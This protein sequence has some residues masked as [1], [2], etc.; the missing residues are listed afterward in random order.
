MDRDKTLMADDQRRIEQYDAAKAAA[1]NEVREEVA[2]QS[3]RL[4]QNDHAQTEEIGRD[5]RREAVNEVRATD[6]EVKRA[7]TV[8][9]ISQVIDYLFYI[10]YGLITL[11]IIFDLFGARRTND[12]RNLID[13]LSSPFLSPFR[14]LF[15]D[16]TAGQ[17]QIRF[18][19]LAALVVYILLHLAINGLLR[20]LVHR[21]TAI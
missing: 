20:M 1:H 10:V 17:F 19:Y 4:D 8:A 21:K 13:T 5:F 11:E 7:R 6:T 2:W 18:S 9:R 3:N 14:N 15:S 16:P 12:F